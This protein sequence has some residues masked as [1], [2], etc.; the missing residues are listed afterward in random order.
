MLYL[1]IVQASRFQRTL[2]K[3]IIC[4]IIYYQTSVPE[5]MEDP[6]LI[7]TNRLSLSR[8]PFGYKTMTLSLVTNELVYLLN[9]DQKSMKWMR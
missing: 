4:V 7:V 1:E 2:L 5:P 9:T 3:L 6:S 8:M